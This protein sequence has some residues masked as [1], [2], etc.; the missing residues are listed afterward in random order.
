MNYGKCFLSNVVS[1]TTEE[2]LC[3]T[4]A[5]IDHVTLKEASVDGNGITKFGELSSTAPVIQFKLTED[6]ILGLPKGSSQ[7]ISGGLCIILAPFPC[8]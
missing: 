5:Q 1:G 3:A 4:I 2:E 7:S 8:G 6:N